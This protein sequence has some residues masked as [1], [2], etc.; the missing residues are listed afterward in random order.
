M[1]HK[2]FTLVELLVV[3]S[4]IGLLSSIAVVSTN[5]TRQKAK[6]AKVNADLL[7]IVKQI[8]VARTNS[9]TTLMGVTGSNASDWACRGLNVD[10]ATPSSLCLPALALAFTR[11]G[12][13]GLIYDPWGHPYMIDENELEGGSCAHDMVYSVGLDFV[14]SGGGGDDIAFP[15]PYFQCRN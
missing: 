11:I 14:D 13:A 10:G 15:V 8:E 3:I 7:Q 12:F 9:N 1:K 4:I 6:I 5:A 2:G